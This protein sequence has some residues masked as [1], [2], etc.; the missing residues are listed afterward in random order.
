MH[1]REIRTKEKIEC[2]KFEE[3]SSC[4]LENDYYEKIAWTKVKMETPWQEFFN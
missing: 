4:Q 2:E 3:I 1:E